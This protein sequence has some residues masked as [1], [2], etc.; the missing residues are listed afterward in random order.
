MGE[1]EN[2]A[3]RF[4]KSQKERLQGEMNELRSLEDELH[5]SLAANAAAQDEKQAAMNDIDQLLDVIQSSTE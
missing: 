1:H 5:A 2:Q 3:I 4:L